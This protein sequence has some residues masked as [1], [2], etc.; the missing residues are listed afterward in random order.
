MANVRFH[1]FQTFPGVKNIKYLI[2][3]YR[4]VSKMLESVC[5]NIILKIAA[6]SGLRDLENCA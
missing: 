2:N 6:I 4:N 3:V 1:E 5:S